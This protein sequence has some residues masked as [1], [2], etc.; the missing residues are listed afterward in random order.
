VVARGPQAAGLARSPP[1]S[2]H[3]PGR[4]V[5]SC[6]HRAL[7]KRVARLRQLGLTIGGP[8]VIADRSSGM[9]SV[10]HRWCPAA[11]Y[12]KTPASGGKPRRQRCRRCY[13]ARLDR[14]NHPL[15]PRAAPLSHGFEATGGCQIAMPRASSDPVPG[16]NKLKSQRIM[17]TIGCI[18]CGNATPCPGRPG[19]SAWTRGG[20]MRLDVAAA[21]R[22]AA[23][24]AIRSAQVAIAAVTGSWRG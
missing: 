9:T 15:R 7:P 12:P 10:L 5:S 22:G 16:A 14:V 3:A 23:G 11:G 17:A 1:F 4:I 13:L 18:G 20:R 8:P 24:A 2:C 19:P 6:L 21:Q